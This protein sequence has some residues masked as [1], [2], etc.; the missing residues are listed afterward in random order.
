[1]GRGAASCW[2]CSLCLPCLLMFVAQFCSLFASLWSLRLGRACPG[3]LSVV[4][5][6]KTWALDTRPVQSLTLPSVGFRVI[7]LLW[8]PKSVLTKS[9][10]NC[11]R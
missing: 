8:F 6:V 10:M 5:V 3:H 9:P 4:L 1:M 11:W 7:A 2:V